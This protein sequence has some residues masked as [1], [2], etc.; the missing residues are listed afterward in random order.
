MSASE[1]ELNSVFIIADRNISEV[2]GSTEMHYLSSYFG[3]LTSTYVF[4]PASKEIED[5]TV[6][7]HPFSGALGTFLLNFIYLPYW[8][9]MLYRHR[10]DLVYCY[11]NVITPALL[12]RSLTGS[13]VVH[14]MRSD[15][16]NQA[17]EF[18][19]ADGQ[20]TLRRVLLKMSE[21][22]HRFILQ[23]S[24]I[25]VTLSE[26]LASDL[27]ENYSISEDQIHLLPVGV[28]TNRF[29]ARCPEPGHLDLIYIGTI[30]PRRGID[31]FVAGL[32][33]LSD[34]QQANITLHLYGGGDEEFIK[35]L[36]KRAASESFELQYYGQVPHEEIPEMLREA[37][38][39]ISPLP[40]LR[41]YQVSS[42]A[43]IFEYLAAG[44]PIVASDIAAHR[45]ILD[46]EIAFIVKHD[47]EDYADAIREILADKQHLT[48]MAANARYRAEKHDW[49]NRFAELMDKLSEVR[50]DQSA[51]S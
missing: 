8:L 15:P 42:P 32:P 3:S 33:L 2:Q 41:A 39:G 17:L 7:S 27:I 40:P 23:R 13:I 30:Q 31:E 12:A 50:V 4:C 22:L 46:P 43:K 29:D 34:E 16:C 9:F 51:H 11:Q 35:N 25:V 44:L 14:D 47:R 10:P 21:H 37:D 48:E 24:H 20:L 49:S 19:D 38:V 36:E 1:F 6:L 45:A 26:E 5:A 18:S 28:D